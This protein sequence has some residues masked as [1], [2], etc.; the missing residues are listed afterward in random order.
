MI[1][2]E[3]GGECRLRVWLLDHEG[4]KTPVDFTVDGC[5]LDVTGIEHTFIKYSAIRQKMRHKD[6]WQINSALANNEWD[7]K[8][9]LV[10]I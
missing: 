9:N 1:V 2:D 8:Y 6:T 5:F 10:S 4:Q 3:H 7:K